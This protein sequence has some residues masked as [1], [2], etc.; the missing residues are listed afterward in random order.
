MVVGRII[1]RL[2]SSGLGYRRDGVNVPVLFYAYDGLLLANTIGEAALIV[3]LL[4]DTARQ[5][6]LLINRN[7]SVC[8]IFNGESPE[9]TLVGGVKVARDMRYLG[10]KV[11]NEWDCFREHRREKIDLAERMANVTYSVVGKACDRL[12]I[13]KTFWKN[14]VLPSVL[15]SSAVVVWKRKEID[16]LQKIEN[17]VWR[18]IFRAPSYT[19]V[20]ALQGEVGCSTVIGRDA[21]TKLK[22]IK[23]LQECKNGLLRKIWH[24]MKGNERAKNWVGC[25]GGYLRMV[26][27]SW[28]EAEEASVTSICRKIQDWEE[29]TW[30]VEAR[31]TL[32]HYR[33]KEKIGGEIYNNSWGSQ[34]LFMA[35]TNTLIG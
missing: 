20:A 10:I 2:M 12:T 23:F 28:P 1:E 31:S 3:G 30:R 14:V 18:K 35:R 11:I 26:G 16:R 9:G 25:V 24:R 4:E 6:G 32:I 22:F 5:C 29:A 33:M 8:L 13:G 15:T 21:K 19:P 34:L 7:K 17:G 27:W